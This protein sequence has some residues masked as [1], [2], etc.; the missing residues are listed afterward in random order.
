VLDIL[1]LVDMERTEIEQ[2][3]RKPLGTLAVEE[4]KKSIS[5][6]SY[7]IWEARDALINLNRYGVLAYSGISVADLEERLSKLRHKPDQR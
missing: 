7:G 4:L 6:I 2:R 3:E 1:Y 5:A